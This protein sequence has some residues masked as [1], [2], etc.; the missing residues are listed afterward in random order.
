MSENDIEPGATT[1]ES[2]DRCVTPPTSSSMVC[3]TNTASSA[4]DAAGNSPIGGASGSTR[5]GSRRRPGTSV[6]GAI[7]CAAAAMIGADER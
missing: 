7:A 4:V 1:R 6:V 2:T 5:A 3:D